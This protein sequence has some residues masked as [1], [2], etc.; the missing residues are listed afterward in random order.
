M[1]L[2]DIEEEHNRG[3][4]P[5]RMV[6]DPNHGNAKEQRRGSSSLLAA[7]GIGYEQ[8][9]KSSMQTQEGKVF[10]QGNQVF[11]ED[12]DGKITTMEILEVKEKMGLLRKAVP[13][14]PLCI[15]IIFCLIN[16]ALPG[17]GTFFGALSLFCCGR[18]RHENR[19]DGVKYGLLAA[20]IQLF[21]WFLIIGWIYSIYYGVKMVQDSIAKAAVNPEGTASG[22][23]NGSRGASKAVSEPEVTIQI[24]QTQA[25]A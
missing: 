2:E 11:M 13:T 12:K 7:A 18:C 3:K 17:I 23:E 20:L 19:A 24:K 15:A 5:E 1:Q 14:L 25:W 21:T 10:L 22:E 9:R 8:R 6:L 16:C 4:T